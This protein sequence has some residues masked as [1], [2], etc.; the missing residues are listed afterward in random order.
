[1]TG[2]KK[3]TES[4]DKQNDN[5]NDKINIFMYSSVWLQVLPND[6]TLYSG[7]FAVKFS[8]ED[9]TPGFVRNSKRVQL[10]LAVFGVDPGNN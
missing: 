3:M 9:G 10:S 8:S 7:T 1:M 2:Q 4:N 6:N 5:N